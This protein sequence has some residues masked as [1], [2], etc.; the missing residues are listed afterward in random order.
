M[1]VVGREICCWQGN[2]LLAEKSVVGRESCCWQGNLL[3][4]GK[5]VVGREIC[6]DL[7]VQNGVKV[8]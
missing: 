4:A 6:L 7:A 2:L 3:L 5:S 8:N 1:Y